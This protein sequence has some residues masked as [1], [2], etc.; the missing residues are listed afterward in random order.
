MTKLFFDCEFTG[1]HKK[2]TLMSIGIISECG[3]IFYAEMTDYDKDH[4][5]DWLQ[6][7]I[8]E[9]FILS[10]EDNKTPLFIEWFRD[11]VSLFFEKS[12]TDETLDI[13]LFQS[14][15]EDLKIALTNWLDQFESV[16]VWS[17][18]LSFNWVLFCDIFGG[19]FDVPQNIY[20]IPFD[21]CTFFKI[22]G[23]DPDISREDFT[24]VF[25]E[26]NQLKHNSLYDALVIKACYDKLTKN[27]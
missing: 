16:E 17:D 27:E 2:T 7:K 5:D 24:N 12:V 4:I 22:K 21:I 20:Y 23:I 14:N 6:E 26:D 13:T 3:K 15:K 9:N 1:L 25:P 10:N 18:Y 11:N 19:A 8:I